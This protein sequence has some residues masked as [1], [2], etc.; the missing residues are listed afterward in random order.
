MHSTYL[1]FLLWSLL[2]C[3]FA[4]PAQQGKGL[5]NDKDIYT[6]EIDPHNGD[7]YNVYTPYYKQ[8]DR[9]VTRL[10]F[11]SNDRSLISVALAWNARETAHADRSPRL[12][13][14]DMIQLVAS[15]RHANR[16]LQSFDRIHFLTVYNDETLTVVTDYF[17]D[18][19]KLNPKAKFPEKLT[20]TPSSSFWPS[21][22]QTPFFK[23]VGWTFKG[24]KKT[25]C[26][27]NQLG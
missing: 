27:F 25:L 7:T 5:R 10:I 11:P 23:A 15:S 17:Q 12:H 2:S 19:R 24:T 1:L 9:P 16:P 14:S 13:L 4:A 8:R 3:T 26:L 6:V 22:Q 21:F 18:W 20:I